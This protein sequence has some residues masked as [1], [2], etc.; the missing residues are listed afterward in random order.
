MKHYALLFRSAHTF[1]PEELKRREVE[2]A[3]WV[4]RV[5]DMGITLDPRNFGETAA[6]FS[7]EGS[8]IISREGSSDP[9]LS[10][11][12]FFDS[13]SREQAVNIARIHPSL[14]YSV[15]VEVRQWT[16]PRETAAERQGVPV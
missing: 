7:A 12:V 3:A 2:I 8:E 1:T 14:H 15:N 10:T 11:I 16:S 6:N 4:K 5:T 13:P 9:T